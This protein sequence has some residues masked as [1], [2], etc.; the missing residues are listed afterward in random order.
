[1]SYGTRLERSEDRTTVHRRP[2]IYSAAL[3]GN[4][5]GC[6]SDNGP[7]TQEPDEVKACPEPAKGLK[8]GSE[9]AVGV[10]TPPPTVT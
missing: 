7:D 5:L 8:S 10:A 4:G 9:A 3:S 2:F 6:A 1:V